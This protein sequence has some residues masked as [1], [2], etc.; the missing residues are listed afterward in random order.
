MSLG[1]LGPWLVAGLGILGCALG[2]GT[3]WLFC[4]FCRLCRDK[5]NSRG[6]R[7]AHD[8]EKPCDPTPVH[9]EDANLSRGNATAQDPNPRPDWL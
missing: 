7:A 3:L 8:A 9:A 2:L 4:G 6:R 5:M 1:S